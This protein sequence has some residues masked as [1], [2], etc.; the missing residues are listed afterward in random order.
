MCK[1]E[2]SRTGANRTD[3][4]SPTLRTN[5]KLERLSPK[6]SSCPSGSRLMELAVDTAWQPGRAPNDSVLLQPILAD[7]HDALAVL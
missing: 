6:G 5:W 4:G 1:T 2:N 3:R 7:M